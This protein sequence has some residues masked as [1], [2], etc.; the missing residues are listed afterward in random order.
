M[1][2]Q[3]FNLQENALLWLRGDLEKKQVEQNA[4]A[5]KKDVEKGVNITVGAEEKE[6]EGKAEK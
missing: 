4:M 2:A 3:W 1:S 6:E 5:K